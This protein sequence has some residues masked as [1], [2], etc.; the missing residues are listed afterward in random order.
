MR[1]PLRK[2]HGKITFVLYKEPF[3]C[4]GQCLFCFRSKGFTKSTTS[5]EDTLLAKQANWSG[6][7]QL[8]ARFKNYLIKKNSGIKCN[9]AVKG[10]SFTSHS[11]DYLRK[12][13][14][15]LYDYLNGI[16]SNSLEEAAILQ[17]SSKDK[18][19]TYKVEARPDQI[20]IEKCHFLA[21]L[22]VTT[23]DIG[24]QSLDDNVLQYNNRGHNVEAVINATKLLRRFGFEVVYHM[25]VGLP[26]SNREIENNI[27][28]NKLWE[29]QFSP[30]A[31]K[32]YPCILLKK[33]YVYQEKL[34]DLYMKGVWNPID[35][36]DYVSFL[37]E[38]SAYIP[39][40]VRVTRLQR[41]IPEEK[42]EVGVKQ[43]IDR[44][45]FALAMNCLW[46][47]S[48]EN[49]LDLIDYSNLDYKIIHHLQG[50]KRY[51]FE[52][53][54]KNDIVLGYARFDFTDNNRA[55]IRD[56]RVLGNMLLIGE[57]NTNE[58]CQHRG[59]GS[60]LLKSIELFALQ[61][62]VVCIYLK[63]SFGSSTW[64]MRSGYSFDNDYYMSKNLLQ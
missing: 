6:A 7:K 60:A 25:M 11:E 35:Y 15:E 56:I 8:E 14:K 55:V 38:V 12:Y 49:H 21:E 16:K 46:Q 2:S 44:E 20:D 41:V 59:I 4:G 62:Q 64:F 5:N 3:Y 45:M 57:K 40:Y 27:Y 13:T 48:V 18:C 50:E 24:V 39:R 37:Y 54:M 53:I 36:V 9:L 28:K 43:F 52:A 10:D 22:G 58:A 30:D 1:T 63:P 19:V 31:I 33:E 51:C 61:K 26:G 29:D 32:I 17:R 23:V 47:R 34:R 42:I